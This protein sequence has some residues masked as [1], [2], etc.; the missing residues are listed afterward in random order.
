MIRLVIENLEQTKAGQIVGVI[1]L[2]IG[3]RYFPEKC[4]NDFPITILNWWLENTLTGIEGHYFFMDGPFSFR[5]LDK[6]VG[7]LIE[8]VYKEEVI[9]SDTIDEKEFETELR[10]A[11]KEVLSK[12]LPDNPCFQSNDGIL[13]LK[14]YTA[15]W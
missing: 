5:I 9:F 6:S 11:A 8:G 4:W 1:Y 13:K 14:K 3:M 7:Y 15:E 10:K 12:Y 2:R